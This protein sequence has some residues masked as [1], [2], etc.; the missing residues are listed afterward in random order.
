MR[1]RAAAQVPPEHIREAD[2]LY[3]DAGL[4]CAKC[5]DGRTYVRPDDASDD[6]AET[7]AETE[8]SVTIAELK[9]SPSLQWPAT[10]GAS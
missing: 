6:E 9:S 7:E 10:L 8:A 5:R 1:A 3:P 2:L 4:L